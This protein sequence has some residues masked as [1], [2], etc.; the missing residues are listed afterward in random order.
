MSSVYIIVI[1]YVVHASVVIILWKY[2]SNCDGEK[3]TNINKTNN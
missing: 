2:T 3:S 1:D